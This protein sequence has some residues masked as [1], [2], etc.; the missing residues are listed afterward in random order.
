MSEFD[1]WFRPRLLTLRIICL[2]LAFGA[3]SVTA[4]MIFLRTR[5]PA[6][7]EGM[8]LTIV[9][10]AMLVSNGMMALVLPRVVIEQNLRAVARSS[11]DLRQ[12]IF[13]VYQ[14]AKIIRLALVE[15]VA[16]LSAIAFLMEGQLAALGIGLAAIAIMALQMPTEVG[17]LAW[18]E[19]A[20]SR[21]QELQA[22]PGPPPA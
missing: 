6:P 15:A 9:A 20:A 22:P 17:T 10:G 11:G 14:T 21:V 4:V 16:F 13:D 8:I 18:M 3:V 7:G 2:A 12:R 1:A 19:R 5:Q